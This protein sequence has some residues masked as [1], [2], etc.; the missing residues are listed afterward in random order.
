MPVKELPLSGGKVALVD[1]ADFERFSCK[2]WRID[3]RGYVRR[4][5]RTRGQWLDVFLHQ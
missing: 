3:S 2:R 4:G 5:Q 1:E